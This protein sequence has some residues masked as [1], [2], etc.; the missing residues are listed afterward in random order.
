MLFYKCYDYEKLRDVLPR[1]EYVRRI[2][3]RDEHERIIHDIAYYRWC[4]IAV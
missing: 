1:W 2:P 3:P 4:W